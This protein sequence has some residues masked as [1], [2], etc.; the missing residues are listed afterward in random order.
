MQCEGPFLVTTLSRRRPPVTCIKYGDIRYARRQTVTFHSLR[1]Q[2]YQTHTT[3]HGAISGDWL[4]LWACLCGGAGDGIRA[5]LRLE[6]TAPGLID[7]RCV[8]DTSRTLPCPTINVDISAASLHCIER[9]P[10]R[11]YSF[12]LTG[13]LTSSLRVRTPRADSR[14]I[15]RP[16]LLAKAARLPALRSTLLHSF[17]T[18]SLP[19]ISTVLASLL[20][21]F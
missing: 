4:V 10:W 1:C 6:C 21:V 5:E 16:Q 12:N 2:F 11:I 9:G 17:I 14:T 3:D 7:I 8:H 13:A 18:G 19:S 15:C 20:T